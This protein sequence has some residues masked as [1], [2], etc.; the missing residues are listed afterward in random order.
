MASLRRGLP[1]S[2][3]R[4]LALLTAGPVAAMT[5]TSAE[6]EQAHEHAAQARAQAPASAVYK[7][8]FF[9]AHE[10]ATVGVLV[11]LIIPRDERSGSATDA[12]VP[13]F[14]D[15]MMVDQPRR[16]VAMRGGLALVDK[17]SQDRCGKRFVSA[18]DRE[19]RALLDEIAYTSNTDRGLSHAIAFFSSFRDLTATGFFTSKVGIADLRY[20]G[21]VFVD[22]WTGCP[23]A[24][25]EKLGVKY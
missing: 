16:Q 4:A 14:M 25:L 20:V 17:L 10:Y 23:G 22:E 9:T 13:E 18:T 7:R 8:K 5:W 1:M 2:R 11:D 12:G 6:A 24:A 3:R 15:F 19:R 21:N